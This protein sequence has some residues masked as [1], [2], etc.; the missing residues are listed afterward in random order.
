MDETQSQTD[1]TLPQQP[2]TVKKTKVKS[3]LSWMGIGAGVVVVLLLVSWAT[4][5]VYLGV[6]K[7]GQKVTAQVHVCTDADIAAYNSAL[8]FD[9]DAGAAKAEQTLAS[10]GKSIKARNDSGRDATCQYILWHYAAFVGDKAAQKV[11][12]DNLVKLNAKGSYV[13][14]NIKSFEGIE[15]LQ[16]LTSEQKS[17]EEQGQG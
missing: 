6:K 17:T 9:S 14:G 2:V 11:Y 13:N 4:G 15:T 1:Q 8:G 7:P 12:L 3:P 16:T 10:L 5:F